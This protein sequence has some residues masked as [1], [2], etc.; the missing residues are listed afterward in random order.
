VKTIVIFLAI[1]AY[2]APAAAQA[3][4]EDSIMPAQRLWRNRLV[5]AMTRQ[6]FVNYSKEWWHF[7]LPGMASHVYDFPASR[8]R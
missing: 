4:P 1:A 5:S 3:L 2:A 6:G 8:V 7:S